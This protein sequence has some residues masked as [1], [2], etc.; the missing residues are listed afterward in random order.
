MCKKEIIEIIVDHHYQQLFLTLK[1]LHFISHRNL[2]NAKQF[3]IIFLHV[4]NF[5]IYYF[6]I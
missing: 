5:N 2:Y 1:N 3:G 4:I 6:L